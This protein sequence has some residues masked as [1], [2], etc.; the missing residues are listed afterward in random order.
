MWPEPSGLAYLYPIY[1]GYPGVSQTA[2]YNNLEEKR[3]NGPLSAM[4]RRRA[5]SVEGGIF[6]SSILPST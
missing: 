5:L 2:V 4:N 1:P 3:R 6:P